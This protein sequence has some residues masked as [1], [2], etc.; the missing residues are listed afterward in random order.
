VAEAVG[1][2]AN[3]DH[4]PHPLVCGLPGGP[5]GNSQAAAS[6]P[7]RKGG[8]PECC[9]GLGQLQPMNSPAIRNALVDLC[10]E[11]QSGWVSEE[12]KLTR[13]TP[14]AVLCGSTLGNDLL[15]GSQIE[16]QR[17]SIPSSVQGCNAAVGCAAANVADSARIVVKDERVRPVAD[18]NLSTCAPSC[19]QANPHPL[20]SHLATEK[21]ESE[22]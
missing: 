17:R 11:R 18:A 9:S 16:Q 3:F 20:C 15:E 8:G 12:S 14:A 6:S 19:L 1:A 4:V 10:S 5:L 22:G 7:Q 13:Q 21:I 2:R